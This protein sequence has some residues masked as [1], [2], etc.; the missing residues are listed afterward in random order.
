MSELEAKEKPPESKTWPQCCKD[1]THDFQNKET[2]PDSN[3]LLNIFLIVLGCLTIV[4]GINYLF[5]GLIPGFAD[6]VLALGPEALS[7]ISTLGTVMGWTLLILGIFALLAGIGMF[8]EQ[9]WAWGMALMVLTF[10]IANTLATVI[11]YFGGG[12]QWWTS[13]GAWLQIVSLVFAVIGIPW[14]LATKARYR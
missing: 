5:P 13:W 6:I 14:L 8:Q 10:I 9:E 7:F 11:G 12:V 4:Y 3:E 2:I 1:C